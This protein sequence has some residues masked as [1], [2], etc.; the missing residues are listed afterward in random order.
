LSAE[1]RNGTRRGDENFGTDV[2]PRHRKMH[3]DL[4]KVC[5]EGD[6]SKYSRICKI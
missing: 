3:V 6:S 1:G 5:V 4:E 2:D